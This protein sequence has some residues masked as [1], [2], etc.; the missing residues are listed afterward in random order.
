MKFLLFLG[1]DY[2]NSIA[3]V[4]QYLPKYLSQYGEVLCFE[5]PRFNHLLPILFKKTPLVEHVNKNLL[6]YHS[7]G[8]LPRGRT[9]IP[10]NF[11]N[12]LLNY[13]L[14]RRL[15]KLDF[16]K[17]TIITF[18][19]EIAFLK[20]QLNGSKIVYY[21]PDDLSFTARW[22][23]FLQKLQLNFLERKII[24][25][26]R[27]VLTVSI[28]L[29]KRYIQLNQ[30]TKLFP[31]PSSIKQYLSRNSGKNQIPEDLAKI[32]KPIVGYIGTISDFNIN[33]RLL[34]QSVK[35]YNN[36]SFVFLGQIRRKNDLVNKL[37][38]DNLNCHYLGY[39]SIDKL[40]AYVNNF[41]VCIIPYRVNKWGQSSYP[42]KTMEYL[43]FGKPVVTTA[44]PSLKYLADKKLIYWAKSGNEF[45]KYI[46]IALH[47][48]KN[49]LL[50]KKRNGE[51]KKN[52]WSIKIKDFIQV[53]NN[54]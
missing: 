25:N 50:I 37:L 15:L 24:K 33:V 44:I 13:I 34:Q 10:I 53:L 38:S 19:P 7:F 12:H 41:D 52:D 11:M 29:Y 31:S 36:V 4:E 9:I 32:S 2:H 28:T 30:N 35:A 43:S 5:Y 54:L 46:N 22:D 16:T 3:G 20:N 49:N 1:V 6:V 26:V 40:P 21:V 23:N 27:L 18:T 48:E 47:E 8:L 42:V 39:R 51:A 45:I 17:Y 14:F